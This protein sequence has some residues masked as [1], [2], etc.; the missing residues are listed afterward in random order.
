MTDDVAVR[1]HQLSKSFRMRAER[2]T[3]L[4]ERAVRGKAPEPKVFW[5]LRDASFAVRRGSSLWAS[6]ARTAQASQQR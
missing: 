5:A 1:A 6:L 2:R 4:K 3:S